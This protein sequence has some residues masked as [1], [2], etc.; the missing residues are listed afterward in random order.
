[1]FSAYDFVL[2]DCGRFP[3]PGQAFVHLDVIACE[4]I[5]TIFEEID[6]KLITLSCFGNVL[7]KPNK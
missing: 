4:C 3:Y 7:K 2:G 1:M 5:Q 6:E